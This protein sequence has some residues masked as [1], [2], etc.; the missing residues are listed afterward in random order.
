MSDDTSIRGPQDAKLIS[1]KEEHEVRY[2]TKALGVSKEELEKAVTAVG[3]SAEK[4]RA[5]L[6]K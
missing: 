1:L 4:V 3:H 2:W 6:G 5:H